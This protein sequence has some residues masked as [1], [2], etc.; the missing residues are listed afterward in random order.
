MESNAIA[1]LV[2][3]VMPQN[4]AVTT[5]TPG[6]PGED[7][8]SSLFS[9]M[10][11]GAT[12]SALPDNKGFTARFTFQTA[13]SL[14]P[15][16]GDHPWE[17]GIKVATEVA[18]TRTAERDQAVADP[19]QEPAE[20]L[21]AAALQ[22]LSQPA[23]ANPLQKRPEPSESA[24]RSGVNT[25]KDDGALT[26][27]AVSDPTGIQ[28]VVTAAVPGM[29]VPAPSAVTLETASQSSAAAPVVG[30]AKALEVTASMAAQKG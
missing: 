9:R 1:V 3:P 27:G 15:Q 22:L 29:T 16:N 17:T 5:E 20:F 8:T 11:N 4:A 25:V 24:D 2:P 18:G 30:I 23:P 12:E 6:A 14:L 7:T 13:S 10:L 19:L 28:P 21:M 26:L